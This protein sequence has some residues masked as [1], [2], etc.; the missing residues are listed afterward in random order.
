MAATAV[1]VAAGIAA[2]ATVAGTVVSATQGGGTTGPQVTQ[3][4]KTR[5]QRAL[6]GIL[7]R[8]F[9][10]NLGQQGP[11]FEEFVASGGKATFPFIQPNVTPQEALRLGLV[12]RSGQPIPFLDAATA[13]AEGLTPEQQ[14]FL[15]KVKRFGREKGDVEGPPSLAE[16][17]ATQTQKIR[18]LTERIEAGGGRSP[19]GKEISIQELKER[20]KFATQRRDFILQRLGLA[21]GIERPKRKIPGKRGGGGN[22]ITGPGGFGVGAAKAGAD[23]LSG[24]F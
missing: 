14:L 18:R 2:T 12:D 22:F 15:G 19:E 17:L 9:V 13:A 8:A 1:A 4:P 6:E 16:R 21:E 5:E 7:S 20:R 10:L 24:L 11:T 23:F 3:V